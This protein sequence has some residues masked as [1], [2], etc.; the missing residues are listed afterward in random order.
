MADSVKLEQYIQILKSGDKHRLTTQVD[1]GCNFYVTAKMYVRRK[2]LYLDLLSTPPF[3][4]HTWRMDDDSSETARSPAAA[5]VT[6][7]SLPGSPFPRLHRANV[8]V[9]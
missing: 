3:R 2:A 1:L 7:S 6:F 9:D 8:Q 4:S 5:A